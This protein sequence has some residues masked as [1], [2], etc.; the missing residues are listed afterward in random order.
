MRYLLS[1]LVVILMV[2]CAPL[3]GFDEGG[4]PDDYS[5]FEAPGMERYRQWWQMDRPPFFTH[6]RCRD[7]LD[8]TVD[9]RRKIVLKQFELFEAARVPEGIARAPQIEVQLTN[10]LDELYVIAPPECMERRMY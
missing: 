3:E 5:S 8:G 1:T 2:S 4:N 7:F 10:M 9:L 6:I